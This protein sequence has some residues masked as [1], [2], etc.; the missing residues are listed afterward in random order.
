MPFQ[1]EVDQGSDQRLLGGVVLVEV[2]YTHPRCSAY[3]RGRGGVETGCDE[4]APGAIKDLGN[5]V[6]P[7]LF[8]DGAATLALLLVH[9]THIYK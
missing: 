4:A 3:L 9:I 1:V 2:G 5:A 7:R 8:I 6:L